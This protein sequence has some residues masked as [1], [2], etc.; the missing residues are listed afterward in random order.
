MCIPQIPKWFLIYLQYRFGSLCLVWCYDVL[1]I[2]HA[3]EKVFTTRYWMLCADRISSSFT[4]NI[5][6]HICHAVTCLMYSVSSRWSAS[7]QWIIWPSLVNHLVH[8]DPTPRMCVDVCQW[9]STT[10]P[11]LEPRKESNSERRGSRGT[12]T[13][14][15]QLTCQEPCRRRV[16]NMRPGEN[17]WLNIRLQYVA[18]ML[19]HAG[20]MSPFLFWAE[21]LH[22]PAFFCRMFLDS[23]VL[24]DVKA[25]RCILVQ[26]L[27]FGPWFWLQLPFALQDLGVWSL[28]QPG[29]GSQQ[30]VAWET[31]YG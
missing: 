26:R 12:T 29:L 27:G 5:V 23:S 10:K 17:C 19:D 14:G 31:S 18:I 9:G 25:W 20:Q 30:H 4:W 7:F 15:P 28:L 22:A 11:F 8:P 6:N 24:I 16:G 21:S 2:G 3:W 1:W 13:S